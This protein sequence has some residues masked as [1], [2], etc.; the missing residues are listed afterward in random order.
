MGFC[1]CRVLM[2]CSW[3]EALSRRAE[4]LTESVTQGSSKRLFS[5]QAGQLAGFWPQDRPFF[6]IELEIEVK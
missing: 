5:R 2:V 6:T 4:L 3:G 1:L